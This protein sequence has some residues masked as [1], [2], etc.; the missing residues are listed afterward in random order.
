M[1]SPVSRPYFPI[2]PQSYYIAQQSN[3]GVGVFETINLLNTPVYADNATAK[4]GGLADGDVYRT[5]TGDL[6][7]VYT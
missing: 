5:S 7:V 2:P 3:P 1:T 4:A 6:K